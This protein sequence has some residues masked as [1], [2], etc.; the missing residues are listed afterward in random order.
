MTGPRM[1]IKRE[2]KG[3]TISGEQVLMSIPVYDQFT[4]TFTKDLINLFIYSFYPVMRRPRV[5]PMQER[6]DRKV[7]KKASLLKLLDELSDPLIITR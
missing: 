7:C 2:A 1:P 3:S 5:V 4:F 6:K